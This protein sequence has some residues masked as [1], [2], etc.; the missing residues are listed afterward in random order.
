MLNSL[1]ASDNFVDKNI[2]SNQ[3]GIEHCEIASSIDICTDI[4]LKISLPYMLTVPY[5]DA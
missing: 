1:N 2:V 4:G 3:C 5:L